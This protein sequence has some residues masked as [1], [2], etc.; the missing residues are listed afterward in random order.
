[1]ARWTFLSVLIL[2]LMIGGSGSGTLA[3]QPAPR[4]FVVEEEVVDPA[5]TEQY[6]QAMKTIVE[7]MKKA[8]IGTEA[9]WN[10]SQHGQS[11]FYIFTAQS[12]DELDLQSTRLQRVQK[13]MKE[14]IDADTYR[15]FVATIV[16]AVQSTRLFALER[17]EDFGYQPANSVVKDPKYSFVQVHR[18]RADMRDQYR[19][20]ISRTIEALRK[21][22]Y[23]IGWRAFRVVIGEGRA[24][25]DEGR[26]YYYVARYDSQSQ[27]YEQHPLS[28]ALEN[29]LG[30]EGAKQL[31]SELMKCLEGI[32]A[33]DSKHRPDLAYQG[34]SNR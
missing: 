19:T 32:E 33:Y 20:L 31:T 30:K 1:M 10:A 18:V 22:G 16:P 14:G 21:V 34:V 24:F 12:L 15:R 17:A 28:A 29:A 26:T 2:P 27:F 25:F 8:R 7:A 23:P 6:E 4:F 11:H 9:S 13:Q 5:R 3:Q